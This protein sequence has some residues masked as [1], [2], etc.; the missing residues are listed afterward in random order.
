V[1]IKQF[2]TRF[3][4][5][6]FLLIALVGIFNR[7]VDPSWYYRDIEIKGF[8]AIKPKFASVARDIKPALLIRDQPEAIILGSSYAEVGFDPTNPFFTDRGQMK[9][10]NF[11]FGGASWGEVQCDFEF[12]V[13][14]SGGL[15]S[16]ELADKQLRKRFRLHW[17]IQR[18]RH[19][20]YLLCA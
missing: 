3:V 15:S 10:M 5:G 9:S 16:W 14:H 1:T 8:N 6:Y 11:A 17:A 7:I 4:C 18:H 12:A 13:T 20:V 19:V 2:V